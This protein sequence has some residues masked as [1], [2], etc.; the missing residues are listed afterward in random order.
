VGELASVMQRFP[1][2]MLNVEVADKERLD[3]AEEVWEAV[4]AREAQLD[5]TG[6]VLV[7]ASGTEP[8][9]RVMVE[10][11]TE[12][13]AREHAEAVAERVAETLG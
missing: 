3:E 11:E 8:M 13:L 4:R 12:E 2:V 6:R 10:A 9:V 7:R 5:G 1:Q